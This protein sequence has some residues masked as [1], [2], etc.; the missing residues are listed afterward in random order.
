MIEVATKRERYAVT[1]GS[2]LLRTLRGRVARACGGGKM[3]RV[4]V[5]TS[6]EIWALWSARFLES[7]DVM[8][9]VLFLAAGE[10]KKRLR[11]VE[12]LTEELARAGADRDSVLIAFGGGVVGD[13]AGFVAAIY[14]RGVRYVQVPTT[15]LAQVD[16]A[17]GGKTGVNL[18]A[19]KNLV[20]SFHHPLA[21]IADID[22]LRTLPERELRAGLQES[23]K[24]G[25]IRDAALFGYLEKNAARV[26]SGDG[27]ALARVVTAS[28]RVKAAVV[29]ADEREDGLRMILNYGHTVAHAI[30]VGAG[31][32]KLLHGEAVAWGMIAAVLVALG[33]GA[34]S[35]R[36]A[37][38]VIR[39]V[40]MYGPL[41][42][43][44][45]SAK[46]L[47]EL[48]AGDKKNRGGAR[49]FVLATGVGRCE[50][51]GDVSEGELLRAVEAM[52]EVGSAR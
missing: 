20:G 48:T 44:N 27:A 2:G 37:A 18:A 19:G 12:R 1:I 40:K 32:G 35:E 26:L 42:K 31:Y 10:S 7:F 47:V 46:R 16:S 9:L 43:F 17:L 38:R 52:V 30:E 36:E 22:L 34:M 21:V 25:V 24:A 3:A 8:P 4:F 41:R 39:V 45:V 28:V 51:V 14:M 33:R 50:I 13:V 49:K 11:E 29:K 23:V 6:P 5:I 15:L